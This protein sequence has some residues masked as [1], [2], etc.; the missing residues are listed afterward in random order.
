MLGGR[1]GWARLEA[2]TPSGA[3]PSA[4]TESAGAPTGTDPPE[5]QLWARRRHRRSSLPPF[6]HGQLLAP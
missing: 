5:T 3:A 2:A 4:P 6:E 1:E